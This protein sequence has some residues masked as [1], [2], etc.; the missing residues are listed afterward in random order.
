MRLP[1]RRRPYLDF[2]DL[3]IP[4]QESI[5]PIIQ[6]SI[7]PVILISGIGA[8]MI[9]MTNRMGRI[10]D[11]SRSLA[12]LLR[13]ATGEERTHIEQQLSIMFRRAK[14]MQL[15]LTLVSSSMF[16]SGLLVVMIFLSALLRV[17][18]SAVILAVFATSVGCLLGGLAAFIRDV[19][20]SLQALSVEV[21]RAR[22]PPET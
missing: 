4:K 3:D 19:N 21:G 10:V 9:S 17:E 2:G 8:L 20:L 22:R 13:A 15:A 18:L 14:L 12:G 16:V 6:L 5:L 1:T 11:R 7:T